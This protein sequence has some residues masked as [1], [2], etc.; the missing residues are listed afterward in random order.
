MTLLEYLTDTVGMTFEKRGTEYW[1]HCPFH[2]DSDAS[3]AVMADG[4]WHCFSCKRGGGPAAFLAE[5]EGIPLYQAK[6]RWAELCGEA[7]PD[8]EREA[9]TRAVELMAAEG[10]PFLRDRGIADDTCKRFGVGFCKDYGA[11]LRAAGL[12]QSD[13]ERLG[14]WDFTG[15]LVYPFFDSEGVYK[16]AARSVDVKGYRT[17]PKS[18][19]FFRDGLWGLQLLRKKE[20]WVFEGF[21]DAMAAQQAGYPA[22][23]MAGTEMLPAEWQELRERGVTRVVFAPD[24]DLGG[25]SFLER[26]AKSAPADMLVEFVDLGHGDPDEAILEGRFQKLEPQHP[27]EWYVTARWP[28]E[29]TLAR[30]VQ[31][32]ADAAPVFSRMPKAQKCLARGWF[33][34][35]FGDDEAL[36]HLVVG[37]EPDLESERAVIANGLFSRSM[38]IEAVQELEADYFHGKSARAAF[39][40]MRTCEATPQLVLA[41]TGVDFSGCTDLMNYR[42]YIE[43]VKSLGE[44]GKVSRILSQAD[45]GD[46]GGIVQDL[47]RAVDGTQV[48]DGADLA[49]RFMS[50]VNERVKNPGL[51]GI[52]IPKFPTLEKVLL[53]WRPGLILVSGNSG[54]GKT[55]LAAN[56]VDGVVDDWPVLDVTLEMTDDEIMG[57]QVAVRSGIPSVKVA[58]G[59]LEPAEYDRV[60]EAS[61]SLSKG[62]L[63]VA[64]GVND[65]YKIVALVKA[66]AMKRKVR[67]VVIDYL[68]LMVVDSRA[69]RWEQLMLITKTLKN[70]LSPLGITTLAL[71]QLKASALKSDVPDAAD[72]AGSYG[73]MADAD[74]VITLRKVDPKDT[75]DGSNF[76]VSV[77]KNRFGLDEVVIPCVFDKNLQRIEELL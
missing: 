7:P 53:G 76:M 63:Q 51:P 13:A 50:G 35:R 39:E 37:Q 58:T 61:A 69:D 57:K 70:Q 77:G 16:V 28:G 73:M 34:E 71:T 67:F 66:H 3:F 14:L 10:H 19:A 18:S 9:L 26:V 1:A 41:Q 56:F 43:R 64:Y 21:H 25:R 47:Y 24:G 31:M 40:L 15:C 49:R 48:L 44:R 62:N 65:L 42:H 20:A 36:D 46:V 29:L 30:K 55:T 6:R 38:R 52:P 12:S 74:A 27:F 72:Q 68:Q 23:A 11:A 8:G 2:K 75:K 22:L 33:R 4:R 32:L 45:P 5:Y 59:S 17:S 60:F 54:H